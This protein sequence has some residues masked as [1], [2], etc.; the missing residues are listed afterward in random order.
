MLARTRELLELFAGTYSSSLDPET[1]VSQLPPDE[2]QIVE[3]LKALSTQPRLI[4]LDEATARL[5]SRQV[6]RLFDL[7]GDWKA[8]GMGHGVCLAPD[9]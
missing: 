6:S 9:G 3:I 2:R 5:D 1:P 7:I 4:I 8:Q